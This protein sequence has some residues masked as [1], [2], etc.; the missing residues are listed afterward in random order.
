MRSQWIPEPV[1]RSFW[2]YDCVRAAQIIIE[3][4]DTHTIIGYKIME[5]HVELD[6][7]IRIASEVKTLAKAQQI[8]HDW[9][10]T[11]KLA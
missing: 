7:P 1:S 9:F 6:R 4:D 10:T 8:A 11:E 5:A 3:D 2:C